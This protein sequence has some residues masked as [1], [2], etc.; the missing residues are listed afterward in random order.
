MKCA[1]CGGDRCAQDTRDVDFDY[2]G[3]P[4]IL[5]SVSGRFCAD[6]GEITMNRTEAE[7]Y[8]AK[9]KEARAANGIPARS[10]P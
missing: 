2:R 6:C 3:T 5:K 7:D 4:L 8:M 9:L 1:V 10:R